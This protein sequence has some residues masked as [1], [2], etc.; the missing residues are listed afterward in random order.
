MI[1]VFF[2][3][4][5]NLE[6]AKKLSG[7]N[8]LPKEDEDDK[9]E[10]QSFQHLQAGNTDEDLIILDLS[11]DGKFQKP[12]SPSWVV[13]KLNEK[14]AL[15]HVKNIYLLMSNVS[16]E[17]PLDLYAQKIADYIDEKYKKIVYVHV[18]NTVGEQSTVVIPPTKT[19]GKTWRIRILDEIPKSLTFDIDT[20]FTLKSKYPDKIMD[21]AQLKQYMDGPQLTNKPSSIDR[22][23]DHP[24]L[25]T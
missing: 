2:A 5:V 9:I 14:G 10:I 20:L 19:D 18:P 21:A 7:S 13:D 16:K 4:E 25:S 1:I 6:N 12:Q 23:S 17:N 8:F 11:A 22:F 24:K 3:T 15:E